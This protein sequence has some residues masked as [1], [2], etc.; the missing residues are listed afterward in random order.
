MDLVSDDLEA[1]YIVL[2]GCCQTIDDPERECTSCGHQWRIK[3]R[4][5]NHLD[6][7]DPI[8]ELF[9]FQMGGF[10]GAGF[11]VE[12]KDGSLAYSR[13]SSIYHDAPVHKELSK[14]DWS[15]FWGALIASGV[16]IWDWKGSYVNPAVL[17]GTEWSLKLHTGQY[18]K[19]VYGCNAYPGWSEPDWTGSE[20]FCSLVSAVSLLVGDPGFLN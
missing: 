3:R 9:V 1:G 7:I 17:D 2:G 6:E 20:E 15:R 11:R 4:K 12:W 8:P 10:G 18:K 13:G 5:P 19:R 16:C 14:Q